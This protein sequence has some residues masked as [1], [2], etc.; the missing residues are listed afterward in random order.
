M[1]SNMLGT[2]QYMAP[3]QIRDSRNVDFRTDVWGLGA[4][5]YRLVTGQHPFPGLNA[6]VVCA[7]ILHATPIPPRTHRPTLPAA[8]EK[9]ILCCLEK[10]PSRRYASARVLGVALSE[11]RAGGT[12]P[13]GAK[14]IDVR[15]AQPSAPAPAIAPPSAGSR[16]PSSF[17]WASLFLATVAILGGLFAWRRAPPRRAEAEAAPP[18]SASMSATSAIAD[19]SPPPTGIPSESPA[20]TATATTTTAIARPRKPHATVPPS[21]PSASSKGPGM[22]ERF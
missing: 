2:P 15:P 13:L 3:E 8:L 12:S 14:K 6:G 9:V 11:I 1:S 16:R 19:P 5:L 7:D 17:L 21:A 10:E 4:T 20:A 18:T 22:Y